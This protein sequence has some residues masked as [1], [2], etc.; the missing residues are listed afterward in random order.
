[1]NSTKRVLAVAA[2]AAMAGGMIA[3]VAG[4]ASATPTP[5]GSCSG[6]LMLGKFTPGVNDTIQNETLT[7]SLLKNVA[8][9]APIGGSCDNLVQS[10]QDTALNGPPPAS[11]AVGSIATK[12]TGAVSCQSNETPQYPLTGKQTISSVSTQLNA[13][14]KKWQIQAYITAEGLDPAGPDVYDVTGLV[15]KGLDVGALET[16]SYWEEPVVKSLDPEGDGTN[17]T[18]GFDGVNGDDDNLANSGYSVDDNYTYPALLL[19]QP[20]TDPDEFPGAGLAPIT[21]VAFGGGGATATSP[22]L[23]TTAN[24]ATFTLGN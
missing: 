6:A 3:V 5:V 22:F 24:G 17:T 7:T 4:P 8:T 13:I 11:M 15:A 14:G 9:H 20:A 2:A 16:A 21:Q 12:L 23:G 18:P 10:P 19:C 1:V